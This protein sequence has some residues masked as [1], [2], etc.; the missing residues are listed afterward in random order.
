[1]SQTL[2]RA[3]TNVLRLTDYTDEVT[4]L[5]VT[6]ATVTGTLYNPD[7]SAVTGANA[8]AMPYVAASG[9]IPAQYR[10]IIAATVSLPLSKYGVKFHASN[11]DGVREFTDTCIVEDG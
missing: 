3:S 9:A 4:G 6:N 5:P 11:V 1:M 10:G 8:V 7:G 2:H